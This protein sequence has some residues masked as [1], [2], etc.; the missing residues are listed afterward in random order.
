MK[1]DTRM[2]I[3]IAGKPMI[4]FLE[5]VTSFGQFVGFAEIVQGAGPLVAFLILS[6]RSVS[7]LSHWTFRTL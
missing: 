2:M 1:Q 5:G 7:A 4:I 3:V 6:T